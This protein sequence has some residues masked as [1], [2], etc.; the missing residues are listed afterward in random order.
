MR[1]SGRSHLKMWKDKP[2]L[3]HLTGSRLWI[4]NINFC[5]SNCIIIKFNQIYIVLPAAPIWSKLHHNLK[6]KI[7]CCVWRKYTIF[8][9][10]YK[11]NIQ[12]QFNLMLQWWWILCKSWYFILLTQALWALCD[13]EKNIDYSISNKIERL[14]TLIEMCLVKYRLTEIN[15]F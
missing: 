12:F 3:S 11:Q 15:I 6:Y 10:I 4:Y 8:I 5:V 13:G 14:K 1:K 9:H 2:K 7:S